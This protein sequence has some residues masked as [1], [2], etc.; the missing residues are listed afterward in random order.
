MTRTFSSSSKKATLALPKTVFAEGEPIPVAYST[1]GL[2]AQ[3]P[4]LCIAKSIGGVDKYICWEYLKKNTSGV[5]DASIMTGFRQDDS[6]MNYVWLPV[7]EYRIYLIDNAYANL[8]NPDY[9]LHSDPI[10]ISIV[11]TNNVGTT[12]T[13]T[14]SSY[15][16]AT[17]SVANN[18]FCQGTDVAIKYITNGLKAQSGVALEPWL[19]IAKTIKTGTGLFDY[20]THWDYVGATE[21]SSRAFNGSNGNSAQKEVESYKSLP[22][23]SYKLYLVNGSNLQ[24]GI[25]YTDEPVGINIAH[26]ATFTAKLGDTS[27]LNTS[28]P[29]D[30]NNLKKTVTVTEADVEKGYITVSFSFGSLKANSTYFFSVQDV[31]LAKK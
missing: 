4:W 29:Y 8:Q 2:S 18:I 3:D 25:Q 15:G 31:A 19:A 28:K 24:S 14:G 20:Y 30:I 7:G 10:A 11:P 1:S 9:W 13:R 5:I 21:S 23:G 16:S 12:V 22:E 6:L 17:L 26:A 27:L